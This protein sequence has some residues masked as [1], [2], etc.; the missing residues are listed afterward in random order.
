MSAKD[1]AEA[2]GLRLILEALTAREA[3]HHITQEQIVQVL[4]KSWLK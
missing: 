1:V 2:Y 4:K 3:A